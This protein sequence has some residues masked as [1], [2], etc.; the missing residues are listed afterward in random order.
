MDD[1]VTRRLGLAEVWYV[2]GG[3]VEARNW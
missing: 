3:H 1:E 2:G